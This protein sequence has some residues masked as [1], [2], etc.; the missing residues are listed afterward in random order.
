M[1]AV[2]SASIGDE[3]SQG[4]LRVVSNDQD[5]QSDIKSLSQHGISEAVMTQIQTA[6]KAN[7]QIEPVN[8]QQPQENQATKRE[9]QE[10]IRV[11][12][13]LRQL[14]VDKNVRQLY[15]IEVIEQLQ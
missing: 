7:N 14:F 3:S 6:E 11:A 9:L 4:N 12:E 10:H 15:L 8:D 13:A 1:I 5:R 2:K